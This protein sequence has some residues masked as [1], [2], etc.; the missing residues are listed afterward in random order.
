MAHKFR[1][2]PPRPAQSEKSTPLDT[3]G[4]NFDRLQKILAAAGL[5]SRRAC[6]ELITTGRVE[7]DGK[8][9]TKLGSKAD[10]SIQTIRVDGEPLPKPKLRYFMVNKPL[11]VVTTNS[12]PSGRTRVID[13]VRSDARLFPVG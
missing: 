1:S 11:G 9:V 13:L 5:G 8:V 4:E 10:P 6:E 2:N 12:D 3:D 7:V